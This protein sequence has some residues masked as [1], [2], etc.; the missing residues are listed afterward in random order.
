[1]PCFYPLK[2]WRGAP[3]GNGPAGIVF[4]RKE[5]TGIYMQVP[6]GQCIGC[7]LERSRQWAIRC[8][9]EA[10]MHDKNCFLTLTLDPE[11]IPLH[12]TLDK[13]H[14]PGFI[15]RLRKRLE[16][17]KIRYFHAGEYGRVTRRPH[18]HALIFGYDFPD[19]T[20][21]SERNGNV[22]FRSNELEEV[23]GLGFCEIGSLTFESA[24]YV[25]RYIVDKITGNVAE[26]YYDGREP[27]FATMSTRPGI[28]R[29]WFDKWWR[30]VYPS[31]QVVIR[32]KVMKPPAYY[33]RILEAERPDMFEAVKT[34]RTK[35]RHKE[36]ETEE[37][38]AVIETCTKARLTLRGER[39]L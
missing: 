30:D 33:D 20:K 21:W 6:C 8:V 18:Y 2:G 28:G 24:Q 10:K 14:F 16:P 17:L 26:E 29:M 15:K 32:G 22:V 12:G 11:Y 39:G 4:S 19:K 27:E 7:R 23:W 37:R 1:M 31:D 13:T 34:A 38:L 35:K 3:N 36:D 25:A 5:S 9:H